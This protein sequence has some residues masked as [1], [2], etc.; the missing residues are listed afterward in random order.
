[1]LG[2]GAGSLKAA[3]AAYANRFLYQKALAAGGQ[4]FG[5]TGQP[6]GEVTPEQ[7]QA[8]VEMVEKAKARGNAD[9]K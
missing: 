6:H 9:D 3:M 1:M 4:R 5:I 8:A 2:F 7:Q